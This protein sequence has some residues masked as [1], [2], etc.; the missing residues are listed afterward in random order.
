[1][2]DIITQYPT[3]LSDARLQQAVT[4]LQKEF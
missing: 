1:V 2:T 3:M 4:F